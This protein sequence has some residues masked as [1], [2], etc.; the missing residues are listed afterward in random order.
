MNHYLPSQLETTLEKA[1][2]HL[3]VH[4]VCSSNLHMDRPEAY[5][6][7]EKLFNTKNAK[8]E[9]KV[10]STA[11]NW[12]SCKGRTLKLELHEQANPPVLVQYPG[13]IIW[14]GCS[15][16]GQIISESHTFEL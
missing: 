5:I 1:F 7:W 11:L 16:L 8:Y 14:V 13:Q 12:G 2:D 9:D 3:K 10:R 6:I 4:L 15:F